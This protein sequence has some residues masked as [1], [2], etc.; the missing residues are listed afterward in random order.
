MNVG[1][2][3]VAFFPKINVPPNHN[4]ATI[5]IVPKNSLIG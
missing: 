2:S 4:T 3:M 5:R 1:A